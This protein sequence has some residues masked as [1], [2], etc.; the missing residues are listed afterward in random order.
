MVRPPDI[1]APLKPQRRPELRLPAGAT[2]CHAHVFGVQD[3]YPLLPDTHF[4]PHECAWSSYAAMLRS[5][6]CERA[7]LVQ[8]S[9]YGADNSAIEDTLASS[10]GMDL[11]AIAV[12]RP[13]V[14]DAE[15]Q[16]LD[17]LGFRGI[18]LNLAA[19]TKGLSLEHA[20]PLADRIRHLGWHLQVYAD[21]R[22]QPEIGEV[23][24]ALPVPVVIDHF[25]RVEAAGGLD[26]PGARALLRTLAKGNC[27]A[28]LSAPYFVSQQF[29]HYG[30]VAPIAGAMLVRAADRLV[31][32]TDW[33]HVSARER[34][35][36]DADLADLLG[37]WLPNEAARQM[38][39]VDNPA[40]LYGFATTST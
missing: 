40:R 38:V 20:R 8:P 26:S 14:S 25:G 11:R 16:R 29:P 7:V 37:S 34:M 5:I 17:G 15:L 32:G 19:A 4:V 1:P 30:D 10:H 31:W 13:D 21:F 6:G 23:L 12:V 9:V 22:Q 24:A 18:R 3:R 28:K 39:L 36:A 2:D 35:P 27:W 33:P